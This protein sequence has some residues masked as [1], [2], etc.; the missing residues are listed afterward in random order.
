MASLSRGL[1]HPNMRTQLLRPRAVIN[2]SELSSPSQSRLR[3]FTTSRFRLRAAQPRTTS[4]PAS[5]KATR[6]SSS[7]PQTSYALVKSLATKPTPTVLYE[8]PSNFWFYFGCWTSGLSILTWTAL[9]G[10]FVLFYEPVAAEG[11]QGLPEWVTW[12]N[13]SS[14]VLLAAMGFYLISKTPNIVKTIRVL[15]APAKL[16]P[17][18]LATPTAAPA[19]APSTTTLQM[20]VTVQRMLPLLKP[21]VLVRPLDRVSLK[22]RLS[23]PEEYVPELRRLELERIKRQREAE[24]HKYDMEHLLTMPIR[25]LARGV[26]GLFNGV[27]SAWTDMGFGVIRVD[28]KEYKVNVT[29]G[30]AHD[31]FRTLEKIVPIKAK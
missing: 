19:A 2:L 28:G 27:R 6:P 29:K 1:F 9:T 17:A 18:P 4:T 14:Y 21:K 7:P 15:P 24:Q 13:G 25:R 10:P 11:A 8:G 31:G 20:E 26:T 3:L 16:R 12:I 23:L 5:T 30:F 22:S